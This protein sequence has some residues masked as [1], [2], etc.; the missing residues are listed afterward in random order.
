M[1]ILFIYL[2]DKEYWRESREWAFYIE[3]REQLDRYIGEHPGINKFLIH[4]VFVY[5]RIL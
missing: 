1:N 5:I 4:Y 3:L 2:S